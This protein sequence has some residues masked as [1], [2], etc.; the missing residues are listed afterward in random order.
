MKLYI[1]SDTESGIDNIDWRYFLIAETGEVINQW[2]SSNKYWA[3]I[4]LYNRN[5]EIQ[6][7]CK[8]KFGE[9]IEVLFLGEDDMT[10]E[11]LKELN[12]NFNKS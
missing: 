5:T 11:R 1:V 2:V 9:N 8:E 12:K 10:K 3:K 6:E 4:D 7:L